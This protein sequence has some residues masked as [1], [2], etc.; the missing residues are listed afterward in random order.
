MG[1][2]LT[3]RELV[4]LRTKNAIE[5]GCDGIIAS[6]NDDPDR[7]R[8]LAQ[9][10]RLL[11]ATPGIRPKGTD[12]N[13]QR[14]IATPKEAIFN[15]ADYLVMGRPIFEHP[16]HPDVRSA[17]LAVIKEMQEGWDERQNLVKHNQR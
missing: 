1:Y 2:G 9:D 8:E 7:I 14:R 5:A 11:I 6:A 10:E 3:A 4:M 15:G 17:A 16:Q 13:D 12:P